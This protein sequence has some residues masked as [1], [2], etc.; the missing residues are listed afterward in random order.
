MLCITLP[1]PF[2]WTIIHQELPPWIPESWGR[3]QQP[4][5]VPFHQQAQNSCSKSR[6]TRTNR[7][8]P[9]LVVVLL[10]FWYLLVFSVFFS[11]DTQVGGD[12]PNQTKLRYRY[13]GQTSCHEGLYCTD[14]KHIH[15]RTRTHLPKSVV[16]PLLQWSIVKARFTG[17]QHYSGLKAATTYRLCKSNQPNTLQPNRLSQQEYMQNDVKNTA[18]FRITLVSLN[19]FKF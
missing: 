1:N 4:T 13:A 14:N 19:I 10:G 6:C 18:H 11:F 7:L 8:C 16:K 12:E 9:T 3:L 2:P 17:Y 5:L 15:T